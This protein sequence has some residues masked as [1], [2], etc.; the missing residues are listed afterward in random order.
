[1]KKILLTLFLIS[2]STN[3]RANLQIFAC[4]MEWASLAREITG[5]YAT[6][7]S[8]AGAHDDAGN[9]SV[10]HDIAKN[11]R[12]ADMIFC[13]GGGL[14][15]TWLKY[16][17]RVGENK[18][19]AL[20][21]KRVLFAYDY[22]LVK[23]E[24]K[25][26]DAS[27]LRSVALRVH[28]NPN[29]IIP[30]A[31]EFTRRISLIDKDRAVYYQKS[32]EQFV[33]KWQQLI[34]LWE[35]AAVSLK[36]KKIIVHDDSWKGLTSWLGLEVVGKIELK[37]N[38]LENNKKMAEL[39]EITKN[40][41]VAAIILG[42]HEDKDFALKLSRLTKVRV[43]GLPFTVGGVANSGNLSQ[44]FSTTI[45]LLTNAVCDTRHC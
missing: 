45:N 12:S 11:V 8:A 29:N 13:S 17:L 31:G 23:P 24:V 18:V 32:Y 19:V 20:D 28:L 7:T 44:M 3:A 1:M 40:H 26:V 22:A 43:I 6:V 15:E 2:F 25:M 14:D 35:E 16:A 34:P 41:D 21:S 39:I 10:T 27:F 33:Q 37:K 4:E 9:L 5:K 36:G 30:I 38:T 42:H